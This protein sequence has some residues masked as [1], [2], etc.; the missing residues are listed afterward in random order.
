MKYNKYVIGTLISLFTNT[1]LL[2]FSQNYVFKERMYSTDFVYN[3]AF[4]NTVSDFDAVFSNK[5]TWLGLK[6]SPSTMTINIYGKFDKFGIFKGKKKKN[7]VGL[8]LGLYND[9]N[10]PIKTLGAQL[11]YAYD[12]QLDR[13]KMMVFGI[14]LKLTNYSINNRILH[15]KDINDPLLP[16][17]VE[18]IL[19]PNFNLGCWLY[20]G[21]GYLGLASTN[22]VDFN[23]HSAAFNYDEIL[24]PIFLKAGYNYFLNESFS[25]E[26]AMLLRYNDKTFLVDI[27]SKVVY[28]SDFS[29][30]LGWGNP[31]IFQIQAGVQKHRFELNYGFEWASSPIYNLYYGN[32]LILLIYHY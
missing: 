12:V 18:N 14:S 2:T 26:P 32:H 27:T 9:C 31:N 25:I 22:I 30:K 19:R 20:S 13:S 17:N 15:P 3:P 11:A 6:H 21:N 1:Y 29:L 5:E 7:K 24:R 23:R 16:Q 28:K 10:G 4:I 8:G